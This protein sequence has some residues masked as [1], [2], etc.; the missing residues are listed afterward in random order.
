MN[1]RGAVGKSDYKSWLGPVVI[2]IVIIVFMFIIDYA[3]GDK[4]SVFPGDKF[5]QNIGKE[6]VS[7]EIAFGKGFGW[8]DY[9]VGKVPQYVIDVTGNNP[10][11]SGIVIIALWI[12]FFLIFA[13]IFYMFGNFSGY[14]R[15]PVAGLL[16]LIFANVK[17]I[18]NVTVYFLTVFALFGSLSAIF[19]IGFVFVMFI[20]FH[21][22]GSG[23]RT[24]IAMRRAGDKAMRAVAGGE[25][26]AGTLEGLKKVGEEL[27]KIGK[28]KSS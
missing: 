2:I 17:V 5:S 28:N 18:S 24:W 21:F 20:L 25:E 12:V 26:V 14:V 27:E 10:Q 1:K 23:V 7:Y 8:L 22:G 19:S 16:A 15:W 11:S 3:S 9:I 4:F 13:D 6:D